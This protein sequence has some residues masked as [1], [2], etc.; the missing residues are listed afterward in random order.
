[1]KVLNLL[2][3]PSDPSIAVLQGIENI[4]EQYPTPNGLLKVIH[5]STVATNALLEGKGAVTALVTTYGF[6]DVLE[7]GRQ[8]RPELYRFDFAPLPPL[9]PRELR[10]EIQERIDHTGQVLSS[11]QDD[12]ID[13]LLS[14]LA[15]Y[16][17]ESVAVCLLFSFVNPDH[18][19]AITGRLRQAGYFVSPSTEIL[20]EFREYERTSTTVINAYV[21]PVLDRYLDAPGRSSCKSSKSCSISGD[22]IKWRKYQ[23]RRSPAKWSS[24]YPF[25]SCGWDHRR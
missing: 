6:R 24:L 22:A 5:G 9:V 12:H 11:L 14:N 15:Q 19:D 25:G 17:I 7:I 16:P 2:S 1:M 8:N 13:Q 4:L 20:P 3:T 23:H 18:E 21:S 10:F